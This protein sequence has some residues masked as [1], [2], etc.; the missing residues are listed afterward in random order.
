[1]NNFLT[2]TGL[3]SQPLSL[4]FNMPSVVLGMVHA[5]M[6]LAVLTMLSVMDGIDRRLISAASTLGARPGTAFWRVYFPLSMP[7]VTA[8]ALLVFI[9]SIAFFITPA[10]LGGRGETMI[11]QL[12]IEQVAVQHAER[13]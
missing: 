6:P 12:V 3:V 8:S 2:D 11:A 10:F 1:I 5:M 4:L 9:S 13:G 7:G